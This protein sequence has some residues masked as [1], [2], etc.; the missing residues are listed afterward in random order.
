MQSG[1]AGFEERRPGKPARAS[2]EDRRG[3][4]ERP[5]RLVCVD[6]SEQLG[7]LG[8]GGTGPLGVVA[9]CCR[10]EHLSWGRLTRRVACRD[11]GLGDDDLLGRGARLGRSAAV[12]HRGGRDD[13]R[14]SLRRRKASPAGDRASERPAGCWDPFEGTSGRQ[15]NRGRC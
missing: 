7:E 13:E 1:Q 5:I 15:E 6:A 9:S 10:L 2:R 14:G 3:G 4:D 12:G 11:D 8:T